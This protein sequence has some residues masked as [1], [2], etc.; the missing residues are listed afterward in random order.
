MA[1][2]SGSSGLTSRDEREASRQRNAPA[3]VVLLFLG[4][5]TLAIV[6]LCAGGL[7]LFQP[8][9]SEEP[10]GATALVNEMLLIDVPDDPLSDPVAFV[11]RGTIE[12]NIAFMMSLRGAYFEADDEQLDGL[13]MCREGTGASLQKP[14]VREHVDRVLRER[15]D[16]RIQLRSDGPPEIRLM[17]VRGVPSEFTFET[18]TDPA[19]KDAYRL[20]TG[21][22]P[23]NLGGEVLIALRIKQTDPWSD[24]IIARMVESIR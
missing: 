21:I 3:T 10:A 9:V 2:S 23:G 4:I 8:H 12:W 22:V 7:Y 13:L 19:T 14:D 1:R 15:S 17:P 18:G 6:G 11:P 5:G 16:G 24:A 20:V